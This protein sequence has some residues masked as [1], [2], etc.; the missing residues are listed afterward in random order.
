MK[1]LLFFLVYL[2]CGNLYAQSNLVQSEQSAPSQSH[3]LQPGNQFINFKAFDVKQK[4]FEFS[5][6]FDGKP[7]LLVFSSLYCHWCIETLPLLEQLQQD[8]RNSFHLVL[9]YVDDEEEAHADFAQ[10]ASYPW[11]SVWDPTRTFTDYMQYPLQATPTFYLFDATGKFV[12][13]M[14]GYQQDLKEIIEHL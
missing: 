10:K 5:T 13:K 8:K 12:S 6:V 2:L 4:E 9:F 1:Y 14:E 7:V 11:I 3:I